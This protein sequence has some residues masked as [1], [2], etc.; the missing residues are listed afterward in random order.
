M[1]GDEGQVGGVLEPGR[2]ILRGIRAQVGNSGRVRYWSSF[3]GLVIVLN[4][5]LVQTIEEAGIDRVRDNL[6][7]RLSS[8]RGAFSRGHAGFFGDVSNGVL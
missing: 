8:R 5:V 2:R 6:R 4:E 3:D 1:V 7:A